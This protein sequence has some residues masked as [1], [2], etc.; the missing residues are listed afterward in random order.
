MI[1]RNKTC[2]ECI[3]CGPVRIREDLVFCYALPPTAA[4]MPTSHDD[5][6]RSVVIPKTRRACSCFRP[7]EDDKECGI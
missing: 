6:A 3:W 2:G 7:M 1:M 5:Y 4:Q